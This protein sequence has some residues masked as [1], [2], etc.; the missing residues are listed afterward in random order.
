M[1]QLFTTITRIASVLL[2]FFSLFAKAQ[3]VNSSYLCL[4]NGDIVLADIGNC[5]T[6][7]V[8]THTQSFYDIAQGDT[9]DT[10]Y[11]I[12]D[13]EL[14]R[15]NVNTGTVTTLG[16]FTIVG[17]TGFFRVDS[18]VKES[19]GMLLGVHTDAPGALFRFDVTAMTA[20]YLGDVGFPSSGDLTYMNGD[21]YLSADSNELVKID[22]NTPPNSTLV[23]SMPS[24]SFGS[25]FGV[26]TVITANPCAATPTYQLVATGGTDSQFINVTN[27]QTTP[28]CTNLVS[29]NIY[30][31]AEVASDVICTIDLEIDDNGDPAPEYCVNATTTLTT[32]VDPATPIGVYSYEWRIAGQPGVVG[33]AA[34][35]PI[36]IN[37]T[38]TYE[39]V[40]T[41][42]GRA[43]PDNIATNNITVTVNPSPSWNAVGPIVA[44]SFYTL[45]AITGTNI[46]ANAAYYDNPFQ[47]GTP[48]NPGDNIDASMFTS[49]PGR[50]YVY[51]IDASGCELDTDFTIRFVD[52]VV[53]VTPG[54]VQ[55]A[56]EG[57]MVTLTATPIPSS[58]YGNYTFNWSDTQGNPYPNTSTIAV[59]LTQSTTLSV[60]VNDSGVI[61]GNGMGFDMTDFNVV[62]KVDINDLADQA[63][64][65]SFTF[66]VI[67]GTGLTGGQAYYTQPNG[68]GTMYMDGD[69]VS[70]ANFSVMPVTLY[71]FDDNNICNDQESFQLNISDL[72]TYSVEVV[73]TNNFFCPG[74]YSK[75]YTN[76]TPISA[77]GS[78]SY[79]WRESGSTNVLST[80]ASLIVNP[81]V[82]TSYECTVI[83]SGIPGSS[84]TDVVNVNVLAGLVIDEI[85]NQAVVG[86]FTFPMINGTNLSPNVRYYTQ[87]G[88]LGTSYTPGTTI[89]FDEFPSYPVT[90][91]AYD[92]N[93]NLCEDEDEFDLIITPPDV[94]V[95]PENLLFHIP[96]YITPNNDGFHDFWQVE[97]LEQNVTIESI[98][99]FDRY[100][101]LLEQLDPTGIGW[102]AQYNNQPLPSSS[103][104]YQLNYL[105]PAGRGQIKGMFAVIR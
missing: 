52:V 8:A 24:G 37:A 55:D 59:T 82:T 38:T 84:V 54:G 36:N 12:R 93:A 33:T 87:P 50:I 22:L 95:I 44:H 3:S 9:D 34:S 88:G 16:T 71:M 49:N 105:T 23:G 89:D 15:I 80:I 47:A 20:T 17:F 41:D 72:P 70:T 1:P 51:G 61:N 65:G 26:V 27:A 53:N 13:T 19:N 11:G 14:Y 60:T 63:A 30:G 31:A 91:Y 67:S 99:I 86:S 78:Y 28:N 69:V 48:W 97:V 81:E 58:A 2:I 101:K 98:Y 75:L 56:C 96:D 76:V 40:V 94:V 77:I 73:A 102:D 68:A 18:L 90:L 32:I 43:A 46:P 29:S 66:P 79:E 57:D 6:T 83:D 85:F 64:T 62:P 103:Y 5:T 42:S 7:V 100:G 45:P 92:V 21:L 35:L 4:A 25:V 39:C 74:E 104:W 10:L